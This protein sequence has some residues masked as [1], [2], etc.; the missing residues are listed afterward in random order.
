MGKSISAH[1]V[2]KNK[3]ETLD[4][5]GEWVDIIGLP[6]RGF[7]M[8]IY[9]ESGGG[10]TTFTMQLAKML[11]MFGK[12]Y[13][14]SS[15]EGE[16]KSIQDALKRA[17]IDECPKGSFMLGDRDT[18]DEMVEKLSKKRS[19][20][21]LVIDSLQYMSLT[22]AQYQHLVNLFPKKN[23]IIIS[24]SAGKEPKGEHAK[25]IKYMVD[26]KCVVSD[27][28]VVASSRFGPT[29]PYRLFPSK[30]LQKEKEPQA[31]DQLTLV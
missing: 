8:L 3:Y 12:T 2:L 5:P 29:Q 18:F 10:K 23:I 9:G 27:G 7:R 19:A 31:G 13:Y 15:E 11:T 16:G 26:V 25:A 24:W 1:E 20:T 22:K 30:K 4:V 6:E 28:L 21:T 14:N 17:R